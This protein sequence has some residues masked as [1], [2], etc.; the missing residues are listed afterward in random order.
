MWQKEEEEIEEISER[1][2]SL[3]PKLPSCN[4]FLIIL[5]LKMEAFLYRSPLSNMQGHVAHMWHVLGR[6]TCAEH[7]REN[8]VKTQANPHGYYVLQLV[9]YE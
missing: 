1:I 8:G 2:S 5:V 7:A 4:I 9:R 3:L 6:A